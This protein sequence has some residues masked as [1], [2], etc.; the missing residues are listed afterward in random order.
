MFL[1]SVIAGKVKD[2]Y[3]VQGQ[4]GAMAT[5]WLGVWYVPAGIALAVLGLFLVM[6]RDDTR[7]SQASMA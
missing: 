4:S 5:D 6:F 3:T 7:K 1:G 2:H